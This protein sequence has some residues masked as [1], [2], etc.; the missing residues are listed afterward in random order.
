MSSWKKPL[1]PGEILGYFVSLAG[2]VA[3]QV[4]GPHD[5]LVE[6]AVVIIVLG[7]IIAARTSRVS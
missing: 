7:A 5:A 3:F 2:F 4:R 1:T 6:A